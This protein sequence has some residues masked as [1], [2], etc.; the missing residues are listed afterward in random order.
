[1]EKIKNDLDVLAR[2]ENLL[3]SVDLKI[4]SKSQSAFSR[5]PLTFT[6]LAVFGVSAV[7]EGIKGI[8]GDISYLA[9]NHW[10]MLAVGLLILGLTGTI[11][12][13]LDK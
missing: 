12:K 4:G 7:S 9:Q 2:L 11:Y 5:Y 10:L 3:K 8:L 6:L 13:K 1:M